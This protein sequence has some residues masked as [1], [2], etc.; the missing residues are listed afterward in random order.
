MKEFLS[1]KEA[2]FAYF[3]I[4]LD[5]AALK[6]FLK[7]RDTNPLFESIRG[8]GRVGIP[9]ILIDDEVIIGFEEDKIN[10][11]IG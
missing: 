6:R 11:I 9:T 1:Q 10:E 3:D 8:S 7:L 4:S 5:F 2:D